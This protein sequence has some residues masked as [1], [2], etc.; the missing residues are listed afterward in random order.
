MWSWRLTLALVLAALV[1]VPLAFPLVDVLAR[2][3]AWTIWQDSGRL[4][5]LA[6]NTFFL[7]AGSL[8]LALP[9]GIA[10]AILLFRTDLPFR[11]TFRFL[12]VLALFVPVP[13]LVS[14]WQATL[15]TSGWL[16][17][18]F[19]ED[20]PGQP[21][22]SGLGP[23]IFLN[24]L[25]TLP[26]VIVLVGHGLSWVERELEEDALLLVG[27]VRVLW[28]VTLPRCKAVI[29]AAALWIVLQTLGD[30]TIPDMLEVRTFA[31]EMYLQ[32]SAGGEDALAR[33]MAVSLP[34][35]FLLWLAII[36]LVPRLDRALPPLQTMARPPLVF[37]LGPARW[38][39][40]IITVL[41][42]LLLAALPIASLVW[43]LGL[44]SQPRTWSLCH[45]W[46]RFVVAGRQFGWMILQSLMLAGVV[47]A[48]VAGLSLMI[49]WT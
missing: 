42:L 11:K 5:S 3:Q 26:W 31:E 32:F 38:F 16:P 49:C 4:L 7:I 28:K 41:V 6:S 1:G 12:T 8:A 47:G 18:T 14:A 33:S 40:L 48:L 37:R 34:M 20:R 46:D 17:I 25:A 13:L 2:G 39:F 10:G 44:H 43:K 30:I 15:G 35:V 24:S 36:Y 23:A 45:S 9:L 27:P 21:W 29:A 19:W 22:T